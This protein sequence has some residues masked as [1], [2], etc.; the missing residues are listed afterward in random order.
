MDILDKLVNAYISWAQ[1]ECNSEL[2]GIVRRYGEEVLMLVGPNPN[3][4]THIKKYRN[5]PLVTYLSAFNKVQFRIFSTLPKEYEGDTLM[6]GVYREK[7]IGS[8]GY[9]GH[10]GWARYVTEV[11][12]TRNRRGDLEVHL[13]EYITSGGSLYSIMKKPVKIDNNYKIFKK[14]IEKWIL[15]LLERGV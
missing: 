10:R 2:C 1:E 5:Y 9:R 3:K 13:Y 4:I 6:I 14:M 12:I 7:P 11:A 15:K 8:G